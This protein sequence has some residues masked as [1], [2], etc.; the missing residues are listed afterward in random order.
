MTELRGGSP[1]GRWVLSATVLGS[2]MT[3]IDAS[4]VYVALPSIGRDLGSDTVAST[5]IV[6]AYTLALASFVLL[7][8][9]F[10]DRFGRRRIF[11]TGV[12]LFAAGSAACGLAPDPTVLIGARALQGLGAALLTPTSLA[13]LQTSFV[14][15]DRPRL[16]GAWAGLT[17]VAGALG[18]LL[19]GVLVSFTS[20]R[21]IFLVNVPIACFV[22]VAAHR[23]VPESRGPRTAERLDLPGALLLAGALGALTY[24]LTAMGAEITWASG[25]VA[26]ACAIVLAALFVLRERRAQAPLLPPSVARVRLFVALNA[27][28]FLLYAALGTVFFLLAVFLQVGAGYS[29]LASG[30]A[31]L[32][33]TVLMLLFAPRAGSLLTRFGVRAVLTA[34]PLVAAVGV[35]LL[36]RAGTAPDYVVDVLLPVAV[37]GAGLTLFVSPLTAS[38]L[39]SL[40]QDQ[41]GLASG[42]NNAVARTGNLLA[43]ATVPLAGGL[44][45]AGLG[46]PRLVRD[47]FEQ[48]AWVCVALLVAAALLSL[49]TLPRRA[50]GSRRR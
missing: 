39:G 1:Q 29:P 19:G 8:G 5:W 24:G 50:P 33:V 25:V 42:V 13:I 27:I 11:L 30:L 4:I 26:P 22:W 32:P 34:G 47:G 43:I 3:F 46:D 9:S 15:A 38:V 28:T 18:P 21:W 49:L 40:P 7:G 20:W 48:V 36:A 2:A 23:H 35:A 31:V 14:E 45:G 16:I 10:S 37:F 44:G 6:N 17:G 12:V 41:A